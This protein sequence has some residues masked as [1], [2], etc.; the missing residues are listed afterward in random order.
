MKT[1]ICILLITLVAAEYQYKTIG[2]K[3]LIDQ[4]NK[5]NAGWVA[6]EN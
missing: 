3:E 4:V 1:I 2:A 6:G 5:N